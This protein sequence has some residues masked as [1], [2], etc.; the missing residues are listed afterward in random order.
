MST[1]PARRRLGLAGDGHVEVTAAFDGRVGCVVLDW[2]VPSMPL[3]SHR[4]VNPGQDATRV[5][6]SASSSHRTVLVCSTRSPS[7]MRSSYFIS[8]VDLLNSTKLP[9]SRITK[10][11]NDKADIV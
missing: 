3:C 1:A 4:S 10:T 5:S 8:T 9:V 11:W 7:Q 2:P 6:S